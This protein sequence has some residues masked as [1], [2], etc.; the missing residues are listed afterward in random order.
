MLNTYR[1]DAHVVELVQEQCLVFP[2]DL[3]VWWEKLV[4]S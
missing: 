1:K 4:M 2:S 3:A